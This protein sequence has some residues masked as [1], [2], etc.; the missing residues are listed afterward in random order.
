M[1]LL[2]TDNSIIGRIHKT[3]LEFMNCEL[4]FLGLKITS[5]PLMVQYIEATGV[6]GD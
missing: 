1:S 4:H 2:K 5:V 3:H 6:S